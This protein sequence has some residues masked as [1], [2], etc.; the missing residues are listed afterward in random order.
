[1]NVNCVSNVLNRHQEWRQLIHRK[2]DEASCDTHLSR[3]HLL[4]IVMPKKTHFHFWD[5]DETPAHISWGTAGLDRLKSHVM[6]IL[7]PSNKREA[8]APANLFHL[9]LCTPYGKAKALQL[10][11]RGSGR[12]LALLGCFSVTRIRVT[13]LTERSSHSG[14]QLLLEVVNEG[15]AQR[16]HAARCTGRQARPWLR[17]SHHLHLQN[18]MRVAAAWASQ[19]STA[20]LQRAPPQCCGF[21]TQ[22]LA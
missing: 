18:V 22:S 10:W 14:Q 15:K 7:C 5:H 13:G 3:S 1:M 4:H 21:S 19:T 12:C 20:D 16:G 8:L 2:L 9:F 11:C 17:R 6:L